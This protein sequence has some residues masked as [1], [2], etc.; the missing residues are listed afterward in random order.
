[1]DGD[2][3]RLQ[4]ATSESAQIPAERPHPKAAY[5]RCRPISDTHNLE[6][7]V[8]RLHQAGCCHQWPPRSLTAASRKLSAIAVRQQRDGA[9]GAAE[10]RHRDACAFRAG[11]VARD[12]PARVSLREGRRDAGGP[13]AAGSGAG[14][15]RLR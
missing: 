4:E 12:L 6:A 2:S 9:A 8:Q 5:L 10:G 1:M 11:R 13:V 15:F 14:G 7:A 3:S